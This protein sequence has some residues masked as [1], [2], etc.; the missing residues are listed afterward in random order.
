MIP[1]GMR[2][3]LPAEVAEVHAIEEVLRRR[4]ACFG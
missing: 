4:F 1:E 2:D 3:V